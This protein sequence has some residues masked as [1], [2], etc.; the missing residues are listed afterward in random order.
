MKQLGLG[1]AMYTSD[2]D[3]RFPP[4]ITGRQGG[5]NNASYEQ[6]SAKIYNYIGNIDIFACPNINFRAAGLQK[7]ITPT[8]PTINFS[9]YHGSLAVFLNGWEGLH[10]AKVV[11]PS[12]TIA[13]LERYRQVFYTIEAWTDIQWMCQHEWDAYRGMAGPNRHNGGWNV[14]LIDGHTDWAK[15]WPLPDPP[16]RTDAF[17][18]V[19]DIGRDST[20]G[21]RVFFYNQ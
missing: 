2:W 9:D 6:W 16:S 8:N 10:L 13:M 20:K 19:G 18:K 1:M 3:D 7:I 14:L 5:Y 12:G 17:D 15:A 4:G 11:K 21:T